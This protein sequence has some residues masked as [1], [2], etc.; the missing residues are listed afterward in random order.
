MA[1]TTNRAY[2]PEKQLDLLE[3]L[4]ELRTRII[5]CAIYLSVGTLLGWVFYDRFFEWTS[6]PVIK[7]LTEHN[8][9]F[10]LTGLLEG[11]T[12]KMQMSVVI[13]AILSAPFMTLEGWR[14]IAP[15]LTRTERN[16]A[17]L[18]APMSV[19]LFWAGV[20]CARWTLP[21]GMIWLSAQN[22][23]EATFM[24]SVG[25]S[26]IFVLKLYLAFGLV[27]QMPVILMFLGKIGVIT[28]R[29]LK[30]YWR[31]AVV[32]ICIVAAIVT[33]SGDAFTMIMMCIPMVALYGLSIILV[34][35]MER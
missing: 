11:F 28:S 31:Q 13:G 20:A 30:Q 21:M 2:V 23:K 22:P 9:K 14:F 35:I 18:I 10:I 17:A 26:L 24:P 4:G 12:I 25:Q 32:G 29:M 27:F 8:T 33:P 16:A 7:F 6:A 19:L 5:R 34:R 1:D 15:G 3:H